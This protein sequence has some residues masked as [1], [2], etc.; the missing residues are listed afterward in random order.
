MLLF[1]DFLISIQHREIT[2][3]DY[4]YLSRLDEMIKRKTVN[5]AILT[6]LKCELIKEQSQIDPSD[7]CGI[8]LENYEFGQTRKQ[9]PCKHKFHGDC[10]DQWLSNQS[11]ECP[12]DKIPIDRASLDDESECKPA[13]DQFEVKNCLNELIDK[14]EIDLDVKKCIDYLIINLIDS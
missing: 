3:E 1:L 6:S 14:I 13:E 7:V 9:L 12:L 4:D 8:C 2:P 10:I 11:T 5:E